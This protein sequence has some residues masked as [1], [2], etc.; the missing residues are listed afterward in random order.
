M[1]AERR[2]AGFTLVELMVV[3]LVIAILI[4]IA[5]PTFLGARER[6]QDRTAQA[7]IVTASKA[8][9]A[10]A[11][12]ADAF[13]ADVGALSAEEPSINWTGA[14]DGDLH[15]VVGDVLA[16]DSR[17]VLL[18]AMSN[19]ERWFGL[20]I[21]RASGGGLT[22]GRFTCTGAAESA[23]NEMADCVGNDW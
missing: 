21:V 17:Q 10:L 11:A 23:V 19:T 16:G 8:Q 1:Q 14:T 20:R 15:V 7:N 18:Y 2:E 4:A 12:D 3:V 5:I 22:P 9:S 13:T 6:A